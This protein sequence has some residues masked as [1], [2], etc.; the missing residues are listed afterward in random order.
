VKIVQSVDNGRI[1]SANCRL[2]H[3]RRETAPIFFN[4]L[5]SNLVV[6][7]NGGTCRRPPMK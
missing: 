7:V 3:F 5:R 1:I 6:C 4:S 2:V